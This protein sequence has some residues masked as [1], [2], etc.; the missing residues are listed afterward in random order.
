MGGRKLFNIRARS[1]EAVAI[2][3]AVGEGFYAMV[4]ISR[5]EERQPRCT[6]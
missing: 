1:R 5:G 2:K 6:Q 3:R 4:E